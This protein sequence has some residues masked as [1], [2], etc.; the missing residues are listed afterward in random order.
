M[1]SPRSQ[2]SS[3]ELVERPLFRYRVHLRSA[4]GLW[5]RYDGYV[6][7]S[8]Q[9]EDDAFGCA[10]RKLAQTSFP[11]RGSRSSWKL[12]SVEALQ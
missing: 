7:V 3:E 11:D 1:S 8:A 2:M 12:D 10:V 6:D 4:P 9:S 5:E